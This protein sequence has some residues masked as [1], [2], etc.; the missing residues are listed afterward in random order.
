MN[1]EVSFD[2]GLR[3]Q[4]AA[5]R[6]LIRILGCDQIKLVDAGRLASLSRDTKTSDFQAQE[7]IKLWRLGLLRS[8][9]VESRH[10]LRSRLLILCGYSDRGHRLYIDNRE[11]RIPKGCLIDALQE[12]PDVSKDITLHFHPFRCYVLYRLHEVLKLRS[13]SVQA[14]LYSPGFEKLTTLHLRR[15]R[16]WW[17]EAGGRGQVRFWN[18]LVT[19][20]G[21]LGVPVYPLVSHRITWYQWGDSY[22]LMIRKL[23]LLQGLSDLILCRIGYDVL[24]EFRQELVRSAEMLDRNKNLRL[25]VRLMNYEERKDL[26]GQVGGSLMFQTMAEC[27]RRSVETSTGPK[28][29]E[30]DELGFGWVSQD[31]KM[32]WQ[33]GT[34]VLDGD[35]EVANQFLRR[36]GLDYGLRV[37]VYVEGVTEYSALLAA[38]GEER[39]VQL[40]NLRGAVAQR[41]GKGVAFRESLRND[42]RAQLFSIVM[43]DGDRVDN[44]RVVRLAAKEEEF[45]GAFYVSCPDFEL[46]NFSRDELCEVAAALAEQNGGRVD[47]AAL[48]SATKSVRSGDEFLRASRDMGVGSDIHKGEE[49]GRALVQYAAE[50]PRGEIGSLG[51]R[52]INQAIRTIGECMRANFSYVRRKMRIDPESGQPVAK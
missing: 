45:C 4:L 35:R 8:D 9:L 20:V 11:P 37:V 31:A 19:L 3:R 18:D 38:F 43:L 5:M 46:G 23:G 2:R 27:I 28:L 1:A 15:V 22:D 44:L 6:S 17:A 13:S 16:H 30:E 47:L 32:E 33:G 21:L 52:V 50:H 41:S 29:P 42:L 48:K 25:V 36:L 51:D 14:L 10:P 26:K 39:A 7:V 24:E 34:R 49:W 40:V 12:L